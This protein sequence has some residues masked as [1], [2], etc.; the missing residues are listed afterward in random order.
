MDAN[1][2]VAGEGGRGREIVMYVLWGGMLAESGDG[3]VTY[4][5]GS[6]KCMEVKEGM[7]VEELMK[8]VGEMTGSDMNNGPVRRAQKRGA[9]CEGR[10]Q[11]CGESKQIGK[12]GRK[13]DDGVEVGGNTIKMLDDDEISVALEDA[14]DE[15]A[16]KE[17][18]AGDEQAAEKR[19]VDGN[20]MK[21]GHL[22][23]LRKKMDK[24]KT[25]TLKWKNGV[26]ERIEQKLE[27]T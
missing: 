21:G 12:S 18:D 26:G 15:E 11:D 9:I 25:E 17:D 4:E 16:T 22:E 7:G 23:K 20:K 19:C 6:R 3:K 2:T 13:R 1:A 14:G 10:A 5:G 27:D 24:H 8:M